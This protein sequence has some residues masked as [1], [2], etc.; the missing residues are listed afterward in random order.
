MATYM[1][2]K[3]SEWGL[4]DVGCGTKP[5]G[6]VNVD[7]FR[8]GF[9]L[10]VEDQKVGAYMSPKNIPN[11]VIA[12]AS[13]LPFKTEA[14]NVV[15]SSHTIEHVNQPFAMLREMCRVAKRKAIVRCPHRRGSGA[16]MPHHLNYF[17]ATWF[18]QASDLLGFKNSQFITAYEYP[19]SSKLEKT[20]LRR[21]Q[22]TIPWR[23]L[24]R[25][26]RNILMPRIHVPWEVEAWVN[27]YS[28]P[29]QNSAVHFVVVYNIPEIFESCFSSSPYVS[30]ENTTAVHNINNEPLPKIYNQAIKQHLDEDVWFAFCHQ[31]FVLMESLQDRLRGKDAETVYGPIGARPGAKSLIGRVRQRDGTYIGC[32]LDEDTPVQTL[33][34]MCL[35]VHSSVFRKGLSFDEQFGFHFYGA[36][37]CMQSY[38]LGFDVNV[39]PLKCHH[40]SRTIHG[41]ISSIEYLLSKRFLGE[42][43]KKFLPVRT[44]TTLVA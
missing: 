36:D 11:F 29:T 43:W 3:P 39:M 10:Q 44:S 6:D 30:F 32:Q 13:H 27:K 8:Q 24:N 17:D 31:D 23:V 12:E 14:F 1:N 7:F 37:L 38:L 28:T 34:E 16:V 22:R 2:D 33:D 25:V 41:D 21:M 9:N 5:K 26:E 42:K 18:K 15:F 40:K 35:I 20:R 4:L 19:I